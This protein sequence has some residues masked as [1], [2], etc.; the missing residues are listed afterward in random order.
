VRCARG[1][2]ALISR[3]GRCGAA[4]R[5]EGRPAMANRTA[6]AAATTAATAHAR[7][8]AGVLAAGRP[9][10]VAATRSRTAVPMAVP[11]WAVVLMMPD[12]EPRQ[13]ASTSVPRPVAATEDSPM[14]VPATAAQAGTASGTDAAGISAQSAAA[15]PARPGATTNCGR[16]WRSKTADRLAPPITARL[17]GSSRAAVSSGLRRSVFCRCR[18]TSVIAELV[19]AVLSRPPPAPCR[20]RPDLRS[21]AGSSDAA[22]WRSIRRRDPV[23]PATRW[24]QRAWRQGA[25]RPRTRPASWSGR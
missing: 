20:S 13:L 11:S 21:R 3:P 12:A 17:N 9:V 22:A 24:R 19:V 18:V 2:A 7:A 16:H 10:V 5:R 14:P 23:A 8:G 4:G 6:P 15:M 25:G 1:P